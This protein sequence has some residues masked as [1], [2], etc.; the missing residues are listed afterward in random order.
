MLIKAVWKHLFQKPLA[1]HQGLFIIPTGNSNCQSPCF[2]ARLMKIF[3]CQS[4]FGLWIEEC[5]LYSQHFSFAKN[6]HSVTVS[7]SCW[8]IYEFDTSIL[9]SL[10]L[11]GCSSSLSV[12]TGKMRLFILKMW[13]SSLLSRTACCL[14]PRA[15]GNYR[16]RWGST[17]FFRSK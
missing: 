9:P 17:P 3:I 7:V 4:I 6:T 16:V 8:R 14:F 2:A 10:F 13:S 12:L 15:S 5:A 1:W 11:A